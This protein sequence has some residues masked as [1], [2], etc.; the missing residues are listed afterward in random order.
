M[1]KENLEEKLEQGSHGKSEPVKRQRRG[2]HLL[3]VL[4]LSAGTGITEIEI[5]NRLNEVGVKSVGPTN[6]SHGTYNIL[7]KIT[8]NPIFHKASSFLVS[9]G[10]SGGPYDTLGIFAAAASFMVGGISAASYLHGARNENSDGK[11]AG[12]G[13]SAASLLSLTSGLYMG[14]LAFPSIIKTAVYNAPFTDLAVGAIGAGLIMNGVY[15]GIKHF[16]YKHKG[17]KVQ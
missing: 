14:F 7:S 3:G 15:S 16:E 6:L 10:V 1:E 17:N 2:R 4:G 5:L 12:R 8:S 11:N 13:A 9:A